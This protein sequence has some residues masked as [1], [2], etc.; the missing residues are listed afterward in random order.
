MVCYGFKRM[1]YYIYCTTFPSTF[2]IKKTV[3]VEQKHLTLVALL[4]QQMPRHQDQLL[5]LGSGF[6]WRP[7]HKS[8]SMLGWVRI[9]NLNRLS[10]NWKTN[11]EV[12]KQAT[13]LD[14][15]KPKTPSL[16]P[17]LPSTVVT[18]LFWI[19][20]RLEEPRELPLVTLQ[21]GSGGTGK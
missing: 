1:P 14:A 10:N 2:L 3:T 16:V 7:N 17:F 6:G 19:G 21:A 12:S 5:H 9:S 15:R 4:R 8:C 18:T 13:L 20:A 11:N